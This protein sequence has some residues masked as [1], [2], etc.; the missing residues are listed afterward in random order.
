[1]QRWRTS[2]VIPEPVSLTCNTTWSPSA[3]TR[4]RIVPLT[5]T[6]STALK[7]RFVNNSRRLDS[8]PAMLGTG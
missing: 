6:A 2:S 3:V 1:M 8:S 7:I 4:R 5:A